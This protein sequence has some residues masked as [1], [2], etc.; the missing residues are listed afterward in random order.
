MKFIT[1]FNNIPFTYIVLDVFLPREP[2]EVTAFRSKMH[3]V[4]QEK[5]C[6]SLVYGPD[7]EK[8]RCMQWV[9]ETIDILQKVV[10]KL[11]QN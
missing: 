5:K 2:T 6:I 10:S 3:T 4:I 1:A 7:K 11:L 9:L 8:K